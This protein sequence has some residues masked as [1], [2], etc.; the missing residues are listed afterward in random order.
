MLNRTLHNA[1]ALQ[2]IV[3]AVVSV[4]DQRFPR[5]FVFLVF[6]Y[7]SSASIPWLSNFWVGVM[8]MVRLRPPG[9][10]ERLCTPWF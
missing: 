6:S 2:E 5:N 10:G 7:F 1:G 8:A 4:N 3:E 9:E